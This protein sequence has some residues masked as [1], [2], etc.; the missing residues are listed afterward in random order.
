MSGD[1]RNTDV[2]TVI[3]S[4][5]QLVSVP[6][7]RDGRRDAEGRPPVGPNNQQRAA[8]LLSPD[9][10]IDKGILRLRPEQAV[11][12]TEAAHAPVA[13]EMRD[14]DAAPRGHAP[15]QPARKAARIDKASA[16]EAPAVVWQESATED[17]ATEATVAATRP[18]STRNREVSE[19]IGM[20]AASPTAAA[21]DV[22]AADAG[23]RVVDEVALR[24]LIA[25][26]V[27][28]ELRGI[29]GQRA[30]AYIRRLIRREVELA[31]AAE[32]SGGCPAEAV[33]LAAVDGVEPK[34]ED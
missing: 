28:D 18:V 24:A 25:E 33:R 15:Q 8:L 7:D 20:A 13:A 6:R 5:R 21:G 22:P 32:R 2:E 14:N 19:P 34:D 16:Q 3:L 31:L 27:R 1:G 11:P 23:G 30:S 29:T 17:H 10:R 9:L 12:P 4:V 26:L